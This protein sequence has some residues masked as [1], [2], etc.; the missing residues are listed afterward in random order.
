VPLPTDLHIPTT[1][2]G[3]LAARIDRLAPDEKALLQQLAVIG[4]EFPLGLVRQVVPRSEDELYRVLASLQHKEFLY[5]QP[6]LPE[7]EYIF[8]HALVQEAA[9]GSILAERR[10]G[11]HRR[12]ADAIERLF[13]DRLD[14]FASLLAYHYTRAEHWEKAQEYLF[15]AG[16]QAGRMAADTEALEHFRQAEAAYLK[17]FGDRLSSLQRASLARNIGAA[18]YGTGHYEQAHEQFRR[19]LLQLGLHYPTSRWGVRRAILRYLAA[20]LIRRLRRRVGMPIERDMDPAS[21]REISS[22]CHVMNWVDYRLDKER[23]VLD[24]LLE[25]HVG[26]RSNYSPA[27]A[28]G[29]SSLGAIFMTLNARNLARRYHTEACAV[30]RC[31]NDPSGIAF[32]WFALGVLDFFEGS[33]D[34]CESVL[35]KAATAYREAG[36]IHGWGAPTT[37]LSYVAYFRGNLPRLATLCEELVRA[38]QDTADPQ[39]AS[40]GFICL[41]Y[42]GLARGPLD[43][44]AVHLRKAQALAVKIPAWQT[45][46]FTIGLLSKCHVLQGRLDDALAIL[47]QALRIIKMEKLRLPLDQVQV[48]TGLAT[49]NLALADRLEGSAQ[50]EAIRDA[51]RACHEALRCAHQLPGW[52]PEALRLHGTSDYLSGNQAAAQKCWRESITV[53]EKSAFPIERARTLLEI[54]HRTSSVDLVEQALEVFRQT[55]AKVFLAFALH[56]LAQLHSR[57][58][59]DAAAAILIY[60]KAI[61]A[62]EE[63]NADYDLGV[64]CRQRAHLYRHLGQMDSMRSD[65]RKAQT[66]FEAVGGFGAGG[67]G[68]RSQRR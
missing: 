59:R 56:S 58:S 25:L 4:R 38:G 12:V 37:F 17:A 50:R 24:G 49:V 63:V 42:P 30:A 55:G 54:G 31:A 19:A 6:A 11:I 8:K 36:D 26:E 32:A 3:V 16:N 60:T 64:A 57:S 10:R 47:G 66:C 27:E 22:V 35:G 53:A 48:L 45:L 65:L 21:V 68:A 44:S 62:L 1:V 61:S 52:L 43:E 41:G 2:Q 23:M 15:K 28:R 33:W 18:L 20:H 40:W 51:R 34:D 29:L 9:Y 67:S 14:E 46:V 13:G 5:E 7:V 39:L